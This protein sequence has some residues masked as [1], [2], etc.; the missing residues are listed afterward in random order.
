MAKAG[1]RRGPTATLSG[2]MQFPSNLK[3]DC[4]VIVRSLPLEVNRDL[5]ARAR[6]F[7]T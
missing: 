7:M 2:I 6:G 4:K 3:T 5:Q 1:K